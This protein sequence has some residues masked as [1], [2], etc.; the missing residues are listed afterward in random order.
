[1]YIIF[2]VALSTNADRS[3]FFLFFI[4]LNV[5]LLAK[6]EISSRPMY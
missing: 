1:M 4:C 3:G 2:F 5:G 6:L